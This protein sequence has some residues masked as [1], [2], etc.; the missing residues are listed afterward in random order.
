MKILVKVKRQQW[1]FLGAFPQSASIEPLS[2]FINKIMSGVISLHLK[3]CRE[4]VLYV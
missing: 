3:L 4:K 1:D 2:H